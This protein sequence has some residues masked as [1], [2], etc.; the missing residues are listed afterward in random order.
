MPD[1]AN[2]LGMAADEPVIF[3][4]LMH[5]LLEYMTWG[6][7]LLQVCIIAAALFIGRIASRRLYAW[8][9]K[10]F[11][12]GKVPSNDEVENANKL[13]EQFFRLKNFF[14]AAVRNVS[15]SLFSW[16]MLMIGSCVLVKWFGYSSTSMILMRLAVHVLFAF[17]VLSLITAFINECLS[18]NAVSQTARRFISGCFWTLVILHFFG[19]LGDIVEAMESTKLPFGGENLTLWRAF[20]AIINVIA[21]LAVANWLTKITDGLVD[22]LQ[23][24]SNLKIALARVIRIV[25]IIAAVIV[26]LSA[27][28]LDLTVL[29]VFSGALGVGLGFGLQKIASNYVSGFIILLDRAIKIG[30][31]VEVANFRGRVTDISTRF[32]VVRNNDGVECLVPNENFVTGTVKNF[33]YTEEAAVQYIDIS[34]AYGANVKRALEIM[35]E[36]GMRERPRIVKNRRGWSYVDS[37]GSYGINLKLGYWCTDPVNG[38]ASLKTAISMAIYERFQ[39]EGIEISYKEK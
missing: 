7:L 36:E 2:E 16:I 28:G 10:T 3:E 30:D 4:E 32:T 18:R 23:L 31:L 20:V 1:I 6:N 33:S 8:A 15:I 11:Y 9:I 39:Q 13:S 14:V 17:A 38:T 29:S 19:F 37:F 34:V 27:V 25:L 21:T 35:L 22:R 26:A 12:G 5:E 24:S